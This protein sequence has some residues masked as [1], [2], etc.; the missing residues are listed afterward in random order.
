MSLLL[1]KRWCKQIGPL[2][3]EASALDAN[4]PN[5]KAIFSIHL[6]VY[7]LKFSQK[8]PWQW[9]LNLP[10]FTDNIVVLSTQNPVDLEIF[11]FRP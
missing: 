6:T 5:K 11:V 2:T 1:D 8:L 3:R 9:G 4:V 10:A 7:Q